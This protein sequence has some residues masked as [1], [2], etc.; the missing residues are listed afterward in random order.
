M[1]NGEMCPE[2]LTTIYSTGEMNLYVSHFLNILRVYAYKIKYS[3][4]RAMC[5][6]SK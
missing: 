5:K 4:Q 2:F 3:A 6:S 1:I